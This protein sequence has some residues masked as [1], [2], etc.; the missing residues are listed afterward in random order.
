MVATAGFSPFGFS[1]GAASTRMAFGGTQEAARQAIAVQATKRIMDSD[2]AWNKPRQN[3]LG[4]GEPGECP[5]GIPRIKMNKTVTEH[6]YR[7]VTP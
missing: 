4:N 1:T 3:R 7:P 6:R 2:R 5:P